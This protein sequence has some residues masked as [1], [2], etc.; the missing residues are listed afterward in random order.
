MPTVNAVRGAMHAPFVIVEAPPLPLAKNKLPS[1]DMSADAKS[2]MFRNRVYLKTD[3]AMPK[4]RRR[5]GPSHY[6]LWYRRRPALAADQPPSSSER[7]VQM[8]PWYLQGASISHAGKADCAGCREPL[9]S[10]SGATADP[11]AM[12]SSEA[13]KRPPKGVRDCIASSLLEHMPAWRERVGWQPIL[14]EVG[15]GDEALMDR[16]AMPGTTCPDIRG[17]TPRCRA[18]NMHR[19]IFVA[20]TNQEPGKPCR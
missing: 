15:Q 8:P 16:I 13:R 6:G 3:F 7:L 1:P 11:S 14:H 18:V 5:P 19:A 2:R 9:R 12:P 10:G 4:C 20:G 17:H